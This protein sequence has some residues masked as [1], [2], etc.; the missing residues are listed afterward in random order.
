MV[1]AG[2]VERLVG[3][4]VESAGDSGAV[5][6]AAGELAVAVSPVS[7]AVFEGGAW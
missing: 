5:G 6:P 2:L 1:E 7:S 4:L 3:R